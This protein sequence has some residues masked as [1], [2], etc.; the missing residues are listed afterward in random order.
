M[1]MSFRTEGGPLII[2][3]ATA[4][5]AWR[6][7]SGGSGETR[8]VYGGHGVETLP[9]H[10]RPNKKGKQELEFATAAEAEV[11]IAELTK[12]FLKANPEARRLPQHPDHTFWYVGETRSWGYELMNATD[13]T[14][15]LAATKKGA[16]TKGGQLFVPVEP[17]EVRLELADRRLVLTTEASSKKPKLK[18]LKPI[19]HDRGEVWIFPAALTTGQLRREKNGA[20]HVPD[21]GPPGG[22][23]FVGDA[24]QLGVSV[25]EG[26]VEL[27]W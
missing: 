5:K 11:V 22:A 26:F 16:A 17:G 10:L 25:S 3:S 18:K 7:A 24:K 9:K 1:S 2:T 20:L 27:T 13:L 21:Q 14:L 12:H 23:W 19:A 15:A 6:G 4:A 8:L